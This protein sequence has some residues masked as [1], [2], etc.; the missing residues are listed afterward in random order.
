MCTPHAPRAAHYGHTACTLLTPLA[1]RYGHTSCTLHAPPAAH[2]AHTAC[3]PHVPRAPHSGHTACTLHTPRA[4]HYGHTACT[5]HTPPAAHSEHAARPHFVDSTPQLTDGRTTAPTPC[6]PWVKRPLGVHTREDDKP[7]VVVV[8]VIVVVT[9]VN[10]NRVRL[11]LSNNLGLKTKARVPPRGLV[12]RILQRGKKR[13]TIR[14]VKKYRR[15][16]GGLLRLRCHILRPSR[17]LGLPKSQGNDRRC[18]G[19]R[20]RSA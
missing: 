19:S 4:T 9:Q 10:D 3:T 8:A 18:H 6:S 1:A 17:R 7:V 14:A 16:I 13:E 2:S 20:P 12:F 11:S 5:L 15:G